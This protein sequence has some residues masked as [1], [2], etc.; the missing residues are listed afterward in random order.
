MDDTNKSADSAEQID[1]W[2]VSRRIDEVLLKLLERIERDI[3]SDRL[4]C[5]SPRVEAYEA[6]C[7]AENARR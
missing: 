5:Q 6:L 7:R 4:M 1:R 2:T 3:E